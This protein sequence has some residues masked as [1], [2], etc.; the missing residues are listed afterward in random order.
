MISDTQPLEDA[1]H[2]PQ[3]STG[4]QDLRLVTP[5]DVESHGPP[6]GVVKQAYKMH[7]AIK[8]E[9]DQ[10]REP[11]TGGPDGAQR[12]AMQIMG[13]KV[14]ESQGIVRIGEITW[15][16]LQAKRK[17]VVKLKLHGIQNVPV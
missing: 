16:T 9:E 10:N 11:H 2:I 4:I 13:R 3:Q 7:T 15:G 6:E 17:K 12:A 1:N 8:A 14:E 5:R